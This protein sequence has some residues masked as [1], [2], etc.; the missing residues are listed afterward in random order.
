MNAAPLIRESAPEMARTIQTKLDKIN[1]TY[2][3]VNDRT[4]VRGQLH[5]KVILR[6]ILHYFTEGTTLVKLLLWVCLL[7][8]NQDIH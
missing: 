5:S 2:S 7:S 4:K 1:N 3:N 8:V 6:Y